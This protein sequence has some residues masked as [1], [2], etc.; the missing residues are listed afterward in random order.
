MTFICN[1]CYKEFTKKQSLNLHLSEKR[2]KSSLLDNWIELNDFIEKIKGGK[3]VYNHIGD[4]FNINVNISI[5]PINRLN[6]EYIEP[7]KMKTLIERYEER[8]PEKLNLLLSDYIRDVIHDTEHPENHAV[9][10]IKKKPPTYNCLVE[11]NEGNTI[12]VIK[13]LRESCELL[14]DPILN[15]LKTKVNEFLRHYKKDST[16]DFSLYEDTIR[17]L[18]G[19]LNKTNVKRALSSVLQN[20]ILNDIQMKLETKVSKT[21]RIE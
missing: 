13:G 10:Y 18:K 6:T 15:T 16:F 21:P 20:D 7:T 1:L 5:N 12:S 4:T 17:Q 9:K 3:T 14:S 2:C 11:D 19:E 8:T